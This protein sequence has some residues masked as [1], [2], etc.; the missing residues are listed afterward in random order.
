MFENTDLTRRPMDSELTRPEPPPRKDYNESSSAH[1]EALP[2]TYKPRKR[3]GRTDGITPRFES[4]LEEAQRAGFEAGYRAAFQAL[5]LDVRTVR[6]L[7]IL[8]IREA[9]KILPS[10]VPTDRVAILRRLEEMPPGDD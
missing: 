9:V 7:R 1:I 2:P 4:M 6:V 5:G 3:P 10:L 8:P